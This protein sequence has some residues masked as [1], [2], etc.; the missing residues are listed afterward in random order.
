MMS[1]QKY[2]TAGCDD[3]AARSWWFQEHLAEWWNGKQSQL[4]LGYSLQ[5]RGSMGKNYKRE[6]KSLG[7]GARI[8]WGKQIK[9]GS[10]LWKTRG[11]FPGLQ[12]NS[13]WARRLQEQL[14]HIAGHCSRFPEQL[15]KITG[16]RSEE[17]LLGSKSKK[18]EFL[19]R[20]LTWNLPLKKKPLNLL[21]CEKQRSAYFLFFTIF[22]I[23]CMRINSGANSECKS[24]A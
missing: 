5:G 12:L 2:S 24:W 11:R 1:P 3:K 22:L 18:D 8:R 7:W 20:E 10:G 23:L 15:R 9:R 21:L 13:L 17:K 19:G 4:Y 6:K 14:R 16:L